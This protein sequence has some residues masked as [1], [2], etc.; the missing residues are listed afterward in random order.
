MTPF[1]FLLLVGAAFRLQRFVTSDSWPPT[2]WFRIK[3][4]QR[5]G[6]PEDSAITDF[7]HCPWCFGAWLTFALFAIDWYHP[8]PTVILGALTAS[9]LVGLI[10]NVADD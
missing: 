4:R 8:I 6:E 2:R 7:F 1:H 3:L 9:A 5:F 10:S